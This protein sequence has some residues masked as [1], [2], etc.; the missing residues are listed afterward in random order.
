MDNA[1]QSGRLYPTYT[2]NELEAFL[3]KAEGEKADK[4]K[5][6]LRQRDKTDPLYIP[7]IHERLAVARVS[8]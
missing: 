7:T 3:A 6:A 1:L 5:L 2:N 4:L 8:R